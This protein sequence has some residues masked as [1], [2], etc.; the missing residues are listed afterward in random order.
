MGHCLSASLDDEAIQVCFCFAL[1]DDLRRFLLHCCA[2]GICSCRGKTCLNETNNS[3]YLL[4]GWCWFLGVV[5]AWSKSNPA[6]PKCLSIPNLC[7]SS[8]FVC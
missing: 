4:I 1:F 3:V 7:I 2:C 5:A 8:C 6:P